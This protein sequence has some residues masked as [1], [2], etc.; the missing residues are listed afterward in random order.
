MKKYLPKLLHTQLSS[1]FLAFCND[2]SVT[3]YHSRILSSFHFECSFIKLIPDA[4]YGN[5]QKK[6]NQ[7]TAPIHL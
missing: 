7:F 1:H 4:E 3:V 2:A 5:S 6:G